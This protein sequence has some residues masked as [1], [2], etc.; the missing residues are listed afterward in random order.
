MDWLWPLYM[1]YVEREFGRA[2]SAVTGTTVPEAFMNTLASSTATLFV[3]EPM[4]DTIRFRGLGRWELSEVPPLLADPNAFISD[5]FGGGKYKINFHHQ[6]TFVCTHN[7]RTWG[8]ERWREMD[9]VE[10]E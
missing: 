4:G 6:Q 9:E 2:G 1:P 5:R 10:F 7:F 8:D 3:M